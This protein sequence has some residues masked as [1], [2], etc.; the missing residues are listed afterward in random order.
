MTAKDP[1]PQSRHLATEIP[2]PLSTAAMQRRKEAVSGGLGTALPVIVSRAQDAIIEDIDGNRI[3]DFGAG[4]GVVNVGNSAPRVVK[5]V[6]EAVA[7]FTHTNFTTVPYMG[8][9]E[10]CEALN[11]L[12]PGDFQEE[13]P[14]A[15]LWC[16]SSRECHQ[17]CAPL[18]K[19]S[20]SSCL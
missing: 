1:L 15:K 17:D 20:S 13:V 9:I 2:G 14:L 7:T 3:I 18:H 4:I 10:V 19:A 12:T 16:G 8:Y 11:R 6:Q 5:A